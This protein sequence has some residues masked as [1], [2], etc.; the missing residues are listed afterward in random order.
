MST[1]PISKRYQISPLLYA[2]VILMAIVFMIVGCTVATTLA[3]T[4]K[5]LPT[6]MPQAQMV[7]TQFVFPTERPTQ[8]SSAQPTQPPSPIAVLDS[9]QSEESLTED[10]KAYSLSALTILDQYSIHGPYAWD[11][12]DIASSG[13]SMPTSWYR[14]IHDEMTFFR[15][16]QVELESIESP[17]AFRIFHKSL[18]IMAG[19]YVQ[20]ADDMKAYLDGYSTPDLW[21]AANRSMTQAE[22]SRKSILKNYDLV[23]FP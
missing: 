22:Y 12:W 14:Y 11:L 17:Y 5:Q 21:W 9:Y 20:V 23:T 15:N 16:A 13:G 2:V 4:G 7:P 8:L 6:L 1:R 19:Y 10:E 18:Q 3:Y